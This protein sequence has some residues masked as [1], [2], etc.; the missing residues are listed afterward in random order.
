[1]RPR[2][3]GLAV[4]IAALLWTQ[5]LAGAEILPAAID[6]AGKTLILKAHAEG[7]Q[8]YECAADGTGGPTTWHVREPI[9]SLISDG[10]TIGRH[11]AG[12]SWQ[13]A[14]GGSIQA[15]VLASAGGASSA[16]VPWLK[17]EV[18]AHDGGGLLGEA[19]LVQRVDTKG[20]T[21]GGACS[22]AGAF[23]AEPYAATY[24]FLK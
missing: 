5:T 4:A 9:A 20:G 19:T 13:L 3:S 18:I 23:H 1:M 7:A 21:F 10:K 2:R 22:P 14:S 17:L 15:K 8:I 24:I 16:D 6:A 11:F 12:P